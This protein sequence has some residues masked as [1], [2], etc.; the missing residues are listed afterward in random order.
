MKYKNTVTFENNAEKVLVEAQLKKIQILV[1]IGE[2][3]VSIWKQLI[4][5]NKIIDTGRFRNSATYKEQKDS[6]IIGSNVEYAPFLE[7]GT[8]RM[9]ARPTLKPAVLDYGKTYKKIAEQIWK[10]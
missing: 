8:S 10:S 9:K 2:K 1:A 7:L 6:V 4:T 5:K 3:A